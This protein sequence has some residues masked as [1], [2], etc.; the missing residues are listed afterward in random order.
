MKISGAKSLNNI[1][2]FSF[3]YSEEIAEAVQN[4]GRR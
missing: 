2:N 4:F 1:A 3:A